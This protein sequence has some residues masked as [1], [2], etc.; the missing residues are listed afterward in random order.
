MR[1]DSIGRRAG[2]A[3]FAI[4]AAV[5][6][7]SPAAW[8]GPVAIVEESSAGVSEVSPMDV[9]VEGD[10]FEVPPGETVTIGYF[11][12]CTRETIGGAKVS[13]GK[14]ESTV[15][16]GSVSRDTI[17]CNGGQLQLTEGI[18][19]QSAGAIVREEPSPAASDGVPLRIFAVM[20]V[21]LAPGC[22]KVRVDT[23]GSSASVGEF[24]MSDGYVD[25]RK[26]A[27]ALVPGQ[28]YRASCADRSIDF[29]VDS[30]AVD[31]ASILGRLVAF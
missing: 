6:L 18:L 30:S 3:K 12:S 23:L 28:A 31:S 21:L 27:R 2:A 10:R 7:L 8:A 20:P 22:D 29:V 5:L 24:P 4:A 9:L 1:R 16:G 25:L 11:R 26:T 17:E 19:A 13:V 15:V 14:R